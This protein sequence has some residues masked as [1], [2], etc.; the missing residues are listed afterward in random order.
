MPTSSRIPPRGAHPPSSEPPDLGADTV[1]IA[2]RIQRI[3]AD[4]PSPSKTRPETA[5]SSATPG[6][7]SAPPFDAALVLGSGYSWFTDLLEDRITL[8]YADI[9]GMPSST[10]AGHSGELIAGTLPAAALSS[11]PLS[12]AARSSSPADATFPARRLLV[13]SGRF[14]HYEGHPY[15]ATTLPVRLARALG[16][17]RLVLTN[18]AGGIREEFQV[19]DLMLIDSCIRPWHPLHG[20]GSPEARI[21]FSLAAHPDSQDLDELFQ[22]ARSRG[23]PVHRGTY[24]YVKGPSYETPAEIRAFRALGADAVGMST[25]PEL[26]EA[27]R[28]ALPAVAFS[29]ITNPAAGISLTKLDHHDISAVGA[30][31]R[32]H[33]ESFLRLLLAT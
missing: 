21:P 9:P 27:A 2:E 7:H 6:P 22:T 15:P 33:V 18:A 5:T 16:A 26:A 11:A 13:F 1:A 24:L 14:H 12:A 3:W 20:A 29:L 30:R 10:V 19:G 8:P 4:S 25:V 32:G 28:L 23:V 17:S 31:S